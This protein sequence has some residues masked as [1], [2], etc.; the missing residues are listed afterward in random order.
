MSEQNLPPLIQ[1]PA[2]TV[3]KSLGVKWKIILAVNLILGLFL[4]FI[5]LTTNSF[6]YEVA[7]FFYGTATACIALV[8]LLVIYIKKKC[9][10]WWMEVICALIC[11]PSLLLGG[12][13]TA[14]LPFALI[15][16]SV[17]TVVQRL[18]SPDGKHLAVVNHHYNPS[19]ACTHPSGNTA[20]YVRNR[21]LPCFQRYAYNFEDDSLAP[22]KREFVRWKD[23]E[24]L[25]V[26]DDEAILEPGQYDIVNGI[27][28]QRKK[29]KPVIREVKI[30]P[31][32]WIW[33]EPERNRRP[34]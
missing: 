9:S 27:P 14:I 5:L 15:D 25:L 30:P 16:P 2:Q 31:I 22:P 1:Q 8:S 4:C 18:R 21:F 19:N 11:L 28:K 12:I 33:D 7:N 32:R 24:T 26:L 6:V 23:N 20:L 13:C 10:R 34:K 3:A 17:D 29:L